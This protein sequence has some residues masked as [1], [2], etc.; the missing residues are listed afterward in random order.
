M[1]EWKY[2]PPLLSPRFGHEVAVVGDDLFVLGGT[3][4]EVGYSSVETRHARGDGEWHYVSPMPVARGTFAAGV[5]AGIVY[6]AGGTG[7]GGSAL[8]AV[9]RYD[10]ERD[11]WG[12]APALPVPLAAASAAGLDGRLY[13]AGGVVG[14]ADPAEH[15]TDAVHVLDPACPRPHWVP[16]APMPTPRARFRL[17]A[18]ATHLYAIGGLP[19]RNQDALAS[20]ER[21]C[22][23]ADR[24]EAVAPMHKRR[25]APGAAV[26][27]NRIVVTG[28][29]PAPVGDPTAR[30]RTAEVFD[31]GTGYWLLLGTLLPHG[32]ASLVC[33]AASA[34]RIL[35]I[36]GSA[37]TYGSVVTIPDVLSL[38]LP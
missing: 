22:P 19:S 10:P 13:V 15:A 4:G 24:W 12:P 18:T 36:G 35:A 8:D 17:V 16:V 37:N 23:E 7:P 25:G 34:H 11:E 28:G 32:R 21:Y 30:D 2:R 1:N 29:G 38:K 3:D 9:D 31:A 27:G 14:D 20:I 5:V 6:A 33:A 26:V